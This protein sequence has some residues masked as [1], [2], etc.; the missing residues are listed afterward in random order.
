MYIL[1]TI[2]KS[3]NITL[4]LLYFRSKPS[5]ITLSLHHLISNVL[6]SY[7]INC[8]QAA[9]TPQ[10]SSSATVSDSLLPACLSCLPVCPTS[11]FIRLSA[12]YLASPL[13]FHTNTHTNS[14]C[15][16]RPQS[17]ASVQPTGI[18]KLPAGQRRRSVWRPA[19]ERSNYDYDGGGGGF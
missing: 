9:A 8:A 3:T 12:V 17:A 16:R 13:P 4:L 19:L 18:A 10:L 6:S 2:L 1:S 11:P 7:I 14:L 15:P 5:K